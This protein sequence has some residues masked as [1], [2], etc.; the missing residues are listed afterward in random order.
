MASVASESPRTTSSTHTSVVASSIQTSISKATET[1]SA[2][3]STSAA[4]AVTSSTSTHRG[5]STS[6]TRAVSSAAAGLN[7]L[8]L[9]SS[10]SPTRT[11][12]HS[13]TASATFSGTTITAEATYVSG[14]VT[15]TGTAAAAALAAADSAASAV[16]TATAT[17]SEK[18]SAGGLSWIAIVGIVAGFLVAGILLYFAWYYWRRARARGW[19]P[20]DERG[21][22]AGGREKTHS[23]FDFSDEPRSAPI[24]GKQR[25]R[26]KP[27]K[28]AAHDGF[29]GAWYRDPAGENSV[30]DARLGNSVYGR[31]H[32]HD[33][34]R[35]HEY[36]NEPW[37][38][39][40]DGADDVLGQPVVQ[41]AYG[42]YFGP[43]NVGD[44]VEASTFVPSRDAPPVPAPHHE[45]TRVARPITE[46]SYYGDVYDDYASSRPG[47]AFDALALETGAT[48]AT[49]AML[50]WLDGQQA[51]SPPP[52]PPMPAIPMPLGTKER[53]PVVPIAKTP[54][55]AKSGLGQDI[56]GFR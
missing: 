25:Q 35:D 41:P 24:R 40:E 37:D 7:A 17:G 38:G 3:Q 32:G 39:D 21:V 33:D 27:R 9:A 4:S 45:A 54:L 46:A 48:P 36:G 2:T 13:S 44:S 30:Y 14:S 19:R 18:S 12:A 26:N 31:E 43:E 56:P 28:E 10:T 55:V 42:E 34:E 22:T 15:L 47:T 23:G 1:S 6:L 52:V 20:D 5:G 11:T 53:A 49:A 50:P 8:G 51:G 29:G 16:A